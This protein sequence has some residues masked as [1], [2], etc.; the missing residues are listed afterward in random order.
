LRV[1]KTGSGHLRP[2]KSKN[3]SVMGVVDMGRK[4]GALSLS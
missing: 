2:R 4:I 1:R 3:F